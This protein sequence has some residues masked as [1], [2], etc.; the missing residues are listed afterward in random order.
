MRR[1]S[2]TVVVPVARKCDL[3]PGV[4][5]YA[6][7]K[8]PHGPWANLCQSCFRTYGCSLG[9]GKGQRLVLEGGK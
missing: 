1:V 9:T 8:I 3:H 5:A 6:D 7:A 2:T 4:T